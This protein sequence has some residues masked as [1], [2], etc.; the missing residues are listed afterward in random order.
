MLVHA[1]NVNNITGQYPFPEIL[2]SLPSFHL[3]VR[4]CEKP[5][6]HTISELK[7]QAVVRAARGEKR[8]HT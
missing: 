3:L 2:P 5:L 7:V 6:S 4:K 1:Y 8:E